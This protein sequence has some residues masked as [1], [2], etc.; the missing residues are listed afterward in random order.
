MANSTVLC[1]FGVTKAIDIPGLKCTCSTKLVLLISQITFVENQYGVVQEVCCDVE[2]EKNVINR[3]CFSCEI[4]FNMDTTLYV[5]I[6]A[7]DNTQYV[8]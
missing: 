5:W 1:I 8:I 7:F 2:Q 6:C 3:N 4:F